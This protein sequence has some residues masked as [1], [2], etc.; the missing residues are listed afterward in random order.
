MITVGDGPL[1]LVY[2]HGVLG[3]DDD[4]AAL[5]A[6]ARHGRVHAPLLPGYGDEPD[7][8][9]LRTMLDATLHMLDVVGSLGLTDPILVGHCMGG[10]L[11]A[12]MAAIAPS[13][14]RKVALVAPLGLWIDDQPIPDVFAMTPHDIADVLGHPPHAAGDLDDFEHLERVLVRNARQLGMA[15]KLLFPIPDRGLS[16]RM[17]R[18]KADV[19]LVWGSE[20]RYV[21][22]AYLKAFQDVLPEATTVLVPDAGHMLPEE[23]A[24]VLA[25]AV[26]EHFSA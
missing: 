9:E 20:D 13:D 25:T 6:L 12:E 5:A 4:S 16:R 18:T 2:L 17:H 14:V 11:A 26:A 1:E 24:D 19:L 10:M 8:P 15:G 21:S 7:A 3:V 23:H 22:P